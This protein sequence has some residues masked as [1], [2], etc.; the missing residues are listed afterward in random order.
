[1]TNANTTDTKKNPIRNKKILVS[2]FS[3]SSLYSFTLS[4]KFLDK[5]VVVAPD[6]KLK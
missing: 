5:L 1:M 2:H 4:S 3:L 6:N